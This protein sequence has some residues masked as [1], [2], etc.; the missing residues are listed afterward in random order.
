MLRE[1]A[2]ADVM[3]GFSH[4]V[5]HVA[6]K[7]AT[8]PGVEASF[9]ARDG[10]VDVVLEKA[11]DRPL[12]EHV[13]RMGMRAMVP[14]R[15]FYRMPDGDIVGE[16]KGGKNEA[17]ED[18]YTN[19]HVAGFAGSE[20][21]APADKI[22][23]DAYGDKIEKPDDKDRDDFGQLKLTRIRSGSRGRP[24]IGW[25]Y[26]KDSLKVG[27]RVKFKNACVLQWTMGRTVRVS[28]G[29]TGM[30]SQVSSRS[31][32]VYMAMNGA[33]GIE[34]P[35]HAIGHVYDVML[36]PAMEDATPIAIRIS[37]SSLP[38]ELSRLVGAIGLSMP[39]AE[40][41]HHHGRGETE[42]NSPHFRGRPLPDL[43]RYGSIITASSD[44]EA[45][46]DMLVPKAVDPKGHD[47]HRRHAQKKHAG[48]ADDRRS[49]IADAEPEIIT[50]GGEQKTV[51]LS[52]R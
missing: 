10:A 51:L 37:R 8:T 49:H 7:I 9:I 36:S 32:M 11:F 3:S 20:P 26:G 35:V 12:R 33:D 28:P 48:G 24:V 43:N 46:E 19:V 17:I 16:N 6:K 1:P 22:A 23:G 15:V 29:M 4:V 34:L 50:R 38:P 52:R 40:N 27:D 30:V 5:G 39:A 45:D 25:Q 44:D 18:F 47:G 42:T 14:V 2:G 41:M 21:T 31:P 13:I